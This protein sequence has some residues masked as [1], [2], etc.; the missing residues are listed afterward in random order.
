M[1]ALG[2]KVKGSRI[3]GDPLHSCP[4]SL[5]NIINLMVALEQKSPSQHCLRYLKNRQ[6]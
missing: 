3:R 5:V 2:E 1:V 4:G 6:I